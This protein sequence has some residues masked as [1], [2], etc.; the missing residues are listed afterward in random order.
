MRGHTLLSAVA[1]ATLLLSLARVGHAQ[2][3][4]FGVPATRS[5]SGIV[6]GLGGDDIICAG[7]DDYVHSGGDDVILAQG[8][9]AWIDGGPGD[10]DV[11]VIADWQ[12]R[13]SNCEPPRRRP[14]TTPSSP[15]DA[16]RI[17]LLCPGENSALAR[18]IEQLIAGHDF[19]V[20]LQGRA[21]GCFDLTITVSSREPSG[22][23]RSAVV[24][25]GS[26]SSGQRVSVHIV[27]EAGTT[28]V[29]IR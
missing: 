11:C 16:G 12:G 25:V 17:F 19:S 7:G 13:V 27:S 15:S 14:R 24:S 5:G 8:G 3:E 29:S 26:G 1:V 20:R 21:D 18:E 6:Y 9:D 10:Q 2:P 22:G 4:C 28:T 23:R